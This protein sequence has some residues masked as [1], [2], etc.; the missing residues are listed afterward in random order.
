MSVKY[1]GLDFE[2]FSDVNLPKH[3]LDRYVSSPNFEALI[4]CIVDTTVSGQPYRTTF[5]LYKDHPKAKHNTLRL[6]EWLQDNFVVAHNASFERAVLQRIGIDLPAS[7][8]IDSAVIARAVGAGGSLE[9]AAAQ[10][11]SMDKLDSG[12]ALI[13]LFCIPEKG[14]TTFDSSLVQSHPDKW[15]D[16]ELY[17]AR[18]A[19]LSLEILQAYSGWLTPQEWD[20]APLTLAMNDVGWTVDTGLVEIMQSQ[21]IHNQDTIKSEFAARRNA[22]DLNL[23]SHVQLVEW[24]KQRGVR[25]TSFDEKHVARML[26]QLDKKL[27][28]TRTPITGTKATFND[29]PLHEVYDLLHT[30]QRLGGSSLKKLQTILDTVGSD[31]QL[32]DQYLHCGAGQT[33]RT[34][35]RGVQMQNLKRLGEV[36]DVTALS[37]SGVLWSNEALAE[38]LRQV[39]TASDPNG[40]LI[41]GDF[42]SIESR[43]LAWFAQADDKLQAYRDGLDI[44]KVQ[45]ASIYGSSYD[46]ITKEQRQTGK[47]GELS[48]GYGAG[49]DAVV[50]FAEGMGVE[51]T[52]E[53]AAELVHDWR[54]ANPLIVQFWYE[55]DKC[56][57]AAVGLKNVTELKISD[58]MTLHFEAFD[59][60][61]SLRKYAPKHA[62]TLLVQLIDCNGKQ[63]MRRY[64]HGAYTTGANVRYFKPSSRKTGDLW[65]A[66]YI[67]PKTKRRRQYELYGGKL[68]GILTQSFS[69]ELF[70]KALSNVENAFNEA[71]NISVC[72][73]FH[74]EIV[75]DWRPDVN[76]W[77]LDYSM[78]TLSRNMTA[79]DLPSLPVEAVV[80]SDYRYIK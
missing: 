23:A 35:G 65:N 52:P 39:F 42:S 79:I 72:G 41:V 10:L 36:A 5:E 20:F 48:C 60:L 18:D 4:A 25:A 44:Y 63:E 30:K 2:T 16:F 46:R 68:A 80:Q 7:Q 22:Y 73:Q 61:S 50:S 49:P 19:E 53:A 27:Q 70:F 15:A 12:K 31:G 69:R 76:G 56:L 62:C 8:F 26:K 9:A 28:G 6:Q 33:L 77:S 64:F 1:I 3:G 29:T 32:R 47:V 51:L 38:N 55:L 21:Y 45:A 40:R 57:K 74:D 67:D 14:R 71:H 59:M 24:C 13:Q 34:T 17:C 11:L 78:E 58:G 43:V 75:V 37:Q 66:T 54:D